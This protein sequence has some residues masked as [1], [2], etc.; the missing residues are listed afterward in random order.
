[1]Q[2][3]LQVLAQAEGDGA[4]QLC[5]PVDHVPDLLRSADVYVS[6]AAWE[7]QSNA[8]LEA[9]ASG[10]LLVL[11]DIPVFREVAG[12]CAFYFA[13]GDSG[14]LAACVSKMLNTD[15]ASLQVLRE[16]ARQRSQEWFSE[17]KLA[18]AAVS[19]MVGEAAAA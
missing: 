19:A 17:G 4:I 7:G 16:S 12:D 1:M 8:L 9:M 11:S 3:E 15:E 2:S 5:A 13:A 6:S 18:R 14:Q 10:C